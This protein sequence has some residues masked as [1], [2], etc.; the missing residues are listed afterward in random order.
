M[1]TTE[2][3]RAAT[4]TGRLNPGS[5]IPLYVQ[6]TEILQER[7]EQGRWSSGERFASESELSAEFQVSR[8]VIRPALTILENNGLIERIKGKGTFVAP[9]KSIDRVQGVIRDVAANTLS[10]R[11]VLVSDVNMESADEDLMAILGLTHAEREVI[12]IA[13]LIQIDGR[14]VAFRDSFVAGGRAPGLSLILQR[15][16]NFDS[17][18]PKTPLRIALKGSEAT[19]ETSFAT[20]FEAD[21]FSVAAGAPTL[22]VKCLERARISGATVPVELARMVYRADVVTI[23]TS[24]E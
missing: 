16:R 1:K 24:A 11:E 2:P 4:T 8:A 18:R 19:V 15:Q 3:R 9:K 10:R 22:L 23:Q 21:I 7:L 12:H 14:I 20:P 5:F 13:S 6:L 17:A